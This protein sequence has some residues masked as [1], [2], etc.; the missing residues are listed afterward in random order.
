MANSPREKMKV[1]SDLHYMAKVRW[2][3]QSRVS[4]DLKFSVVFGPHPPTVFIKCCN[5]KGYVPYK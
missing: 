5:M 4:F 3:I 1:S 2:E